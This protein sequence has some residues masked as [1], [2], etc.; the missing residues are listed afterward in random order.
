MPEPLIRRADQLTIAVLTA[1]AL[2]GMAAWWSAHGGREGLV[3]IDRAAPL[4]YEFLVDV[5]RAEWPELAQLPA[6]GPV[7]ARRIV[8]SRDRE[9]PF[10]SIEEL[11]RVNG[12]GPRTLEGMRRY[13][14]PI[15]G[16]EQVAGGEESAVRHRRPRG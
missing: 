14:L 5:N 10:R 16:G 3:E 9:G 13:L 12:I 4:D 2:A 15:A 7:L 8:A 11:D 6:I 1:V